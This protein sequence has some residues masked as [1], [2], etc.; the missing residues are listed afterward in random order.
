MILQYCIYKKH[1]KYKEILNKCSDTKTNIAAC[2]QTKK[3]KQQEQ[4]KNKMKM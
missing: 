3:H 4:T 2:V 1:L